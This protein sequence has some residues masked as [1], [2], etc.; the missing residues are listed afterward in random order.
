MKGFKQALYEIEN[1]PGLMTQE[2]YPDIPFDESAVTLEGGTSQEILDQ[3]GLAAKNNEPTKPYHEA[4]IKSEPDEDY[5]YE[6]PSHIKIEPDSDGDEIPDFDGYISDDDDDLA[7]E[8]LDNIKTAIG[9]VAL[10]K[11]EPLDQLADSNL[12]KKCHY[13]V[14][15]CD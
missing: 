9:N 14:T 4:H 13:P 2:M 12:F 10:I 3:P 11:E 6:I 7:E 15:R 8:N 1:N 5:V